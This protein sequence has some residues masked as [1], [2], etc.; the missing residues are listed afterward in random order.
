[1]DFTFTNKAMQAMAGFAIQLNKNRWVCYIHVMILGTVM[2]LQSSSWNQFVCLYSCNSSRTAEW[3]FMK[4][5]MGQFMKDCQGIWFSILTRQ[6]QW[7]L[8]L[9]PLAFLYMWS[10]TYLVYICRVPVIPFMQTQVTKMKLA[11]IIS[12]P[13][14]KTGN[15]IL[16][17]DL[18]CILAALLQWHIIVPADCL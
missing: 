6:V 7:L 4:Y 1:M 18:L 3:I 9:R 14:P 2:P 8:T 10:I 13:C 16:H 12:F 11:Y 5:C 17:I 15:F